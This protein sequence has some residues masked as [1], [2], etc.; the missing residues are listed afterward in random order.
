MD[1]DTP[2]AALIA[3][4][5]LSHCILVENALET[6]YGRGQIKE[7]FRSALAAEPL[8]QDSPEWAIAMAHIEALNAAEAAER[9]GAITV[10]EDEVSAPEVR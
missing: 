4:V 2:N 7:I 9:D 10:D 3:L 5:A 1:Q 6:D 8:V